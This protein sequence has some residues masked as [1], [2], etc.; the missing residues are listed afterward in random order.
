MDLKPLAGRWHTTGRTTDQPPIEIDAIDEYEPLPGGAM[1]HRVDARM[2]DQHVEGAEIIG[3][4][5][6]LGHFRTQYFGNDGPSAYEAE[7]SE[8]N[9]VRV[10]SMRGE[11]ERFRGTFNADGDVITGHWERLAGDGTWQRWM[12]ITLTR[13]ASL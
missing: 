5:P 13:T 3:F 7:F 6:A 9:G 2:G 11:K 8:E 12:D 1:L 10:W 4:D